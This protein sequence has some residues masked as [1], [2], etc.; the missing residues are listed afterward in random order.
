MLPI[1]LKLYNLLGW[2]GCNGKKNARKPS[3]L[4]EMK[5]LNFSCICKVEKKYGNTQERWEPNYD[6]QGPV[7]LRVVHFQK[8]YKSPQ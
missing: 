4:K 3:S 1:I 6:I 8:L 2:E 7:D 5:L